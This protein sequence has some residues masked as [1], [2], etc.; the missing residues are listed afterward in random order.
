MR[1]EPVVTHSCLFTRNGNLKVSNI[2]FSKQLYKTTI[3]VNF[4]T[5]FVKWLARVTLLFHL[6]VTELF[7]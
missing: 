2:L 3:I 1:N 4:Y 7:P 5:H 6:K